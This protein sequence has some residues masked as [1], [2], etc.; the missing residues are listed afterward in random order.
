MD[1]IIYLR[2]S[3]LFAISWGGVSSKEYEDCFSAL[4]LALL[5]VGADD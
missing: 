2:E 4:H 5:L 1:H 3:F